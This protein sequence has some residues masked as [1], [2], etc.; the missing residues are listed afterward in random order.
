MKKLLTLMVSILVVLA[1]TMVGS[2]EEKKAVEKKAEPAKEMKA[3][4]AKAEKKEKAK[5]HQITG[6]VTAVDAKAKTVTIKGKDKE[7][8]LDAADIKDLDK[9]KVGDK[10]MAK[11]SEKEGKMTAKSIKAAKAE[12]KTEK[13]EKKEEMKPA[14]KPAAK[15]AAPAYK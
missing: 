15:P 3:E 9:I 12:K 1:F 4:P 8:T 7:V 6:E 14:E 10:V 2:A 13:M 11:Y 5:V